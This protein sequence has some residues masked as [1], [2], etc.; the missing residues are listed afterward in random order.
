MKLS[1]GLSERLAADFADIFRGDR[2]KANDQ[3]TAQDAK[4][5]HDGVEVIPAGS[6]DANT[7]PCVTSRVRKTSNCGLRC[8]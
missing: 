5:K 3:T 2:D 4:R 7:A 1:S 8:K 6:L